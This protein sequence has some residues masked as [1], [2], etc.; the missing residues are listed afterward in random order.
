LHL[1]W[2]PHENSIAIAAT[3]NLFV[4]STLWWSDA[5][6]SLNQFVYVAKNLWEEIK[7]NKKN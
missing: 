4:F 5:P 7:I 1:S 6:L 2:H 3:N